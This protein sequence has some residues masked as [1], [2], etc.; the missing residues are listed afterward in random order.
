VFR[1]LVYAADPEHPAQLEIRPLGETSVLIRGT[2]RGEAE[3][4]LV[5]A[6]PKGERIRVDGIETDA[7]VLYVGTAGW[8][9][10]GGTGLTVA[11]Q[12]LG[13]A[14][15]PPTAELASAL[16]KLWAVSKPAA[17]PAAVAAA[18]AQAK[19]LWPFDGF[20]ALPAAVPA[21]VLTCEPPGEGVL[22]SLLDG[23][24]TRWATMRWPAG[25]EATLTAALR[26]RRQVSQIDFQTGMFG[27][28]NA[29][30]DPAGYPTPRTVAAEF[31]DDGFA[32]DIRRRE[33]RFT[34]DCTF[35]GIHKGSVFP[36]LRWTC[37]KVDEK[38]RYVRLV[39]GKDE[40]KDG[41]GM[42]E[43]SVRPTG[44]NAAR[45]VGLIQRDADGDGVADVLAW[46]DQ[47]EL[48]AVRPDGALLMKKQFPGFITSV[49]CY[50]DL[51]A[52]GPR[53][54]VTTREA[55]LYCLKPDGT[56]VWKTD[57]LESQKLNGDLP[58]AYSIGLLKKP[59]GSPLIMTG[60]YNL[61]TFVSPAGEVLKYERLPAAYQ[62]MTLPRSFDYN[63]D[64]KQEV[65]STE[66]WGTLSV[67]S[68]DMVRSAGGRLP[69]GTGLLL[70]Y[71]QPPTAERAKALVCTDNGVGLL[72]LK[73]LAYD[74]LKSVNPISDCLAADVNGDGKQEVVLAKEDGYLLVYSETGELLRSELIGEPVRAV[75][76]VKTSEGKAALV[77]ALPGRLVRFDPGSG[78]QSVIAVGEYTKLAAAEG[79]SVLLAVGARAT[80]EAFGPV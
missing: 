25:S 39:F 71:W 35:E 78:K 18:G 76:A 5:A 41:L 36:I 59:D 22:G 29:I 74:W 80:I 12:Q 68:A 2:V 45:V 43:L 14:E 30:P 62:T 9:Q 63:G 55:R 7:Q 21:P 6:A 37:R 77:A 8:A 50:P 52:D 61:A 38:A 26:E 54:L 23:V 40:W 56:E 28:Y 75:A 20:T 47:A 3:L 57:F 64:G 16:A 13:G 53:I 66:V 19:R 24:V 34:S 58:V 33:L 65:V 69:R 11:G 49:E 60:N 10:A 46:S 79:G 32:N 44:P 72:N 17:R 51:A 70:D 1:N 15:G 67:L 48:A 27:P 42:T 31:S 4:A 73:T